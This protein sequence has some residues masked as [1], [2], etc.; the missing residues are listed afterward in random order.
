MQRADFEKA[1]N[2][3]YV[4]G[5]TMSAPGEICTPMRFLVPSGEAIATAGAGL[6]RLCATID[7]LLTDEEE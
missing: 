6:V 4:S 2:P 7:F 3:R 1:E 5:L